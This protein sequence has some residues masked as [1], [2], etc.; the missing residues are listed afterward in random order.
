MYDHATDTFIGEET[1]IAHT[2]AM[3]AFLPLFGVALTASSLVMIVALPFVLMG[4]AIK[5]YGHTH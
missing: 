4:E 3:A 1:G 2:L 5:Q